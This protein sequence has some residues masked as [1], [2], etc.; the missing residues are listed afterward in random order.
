GLARDPRGWLN[1]LRASDNGA[2]FFFWALIACISVIVWKPAAHLI[3]LLFWRMDFT[4][5]RILIAALLPLSMLLALTLT[6]LSPP[7][8][9]GVRSLRLGAVGVAAGLLAAI[10][11]EAFAMQASGT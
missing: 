8:E 6:K 11:I 10:A 2:A 9:G 5:A 1:I 4:H 7:F 3:F